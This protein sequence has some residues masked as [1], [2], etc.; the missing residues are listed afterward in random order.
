[1]I[2]GEFEVGSQYH[3]YMETQSVLVRPVEKGQYDVQASTQHMDNVQKMIAQTLAISQNKINVQVKRLGG[4]YGGKASLPGH[5]SAAAAVA[6]AK[7][8]R[9]VRLVMDLKSNMEMLGMRHAF[10]TKYRAGVDEEG[11]LL[12]VSMTIYSDSGF[13]YAGDTSALAKMTAKVIRL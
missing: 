4:A 11:S 3:F 6:A 5:V 10:L 9:P 2:E 8:K 13:S 7:L 1:M 12:F